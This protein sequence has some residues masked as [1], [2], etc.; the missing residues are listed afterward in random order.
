MIFA[1]MK[2]S[3]DYWDLHEELKK[4]LC[5]H[6]PCVESGLQSDSWFWIFIGNEKV[7]IDTFSSTRH[8]VKSGK[9]GPHVQQV[10]DALLLNYQVTV[11]GDPILEGHEGA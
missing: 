9:G 4:F 7:A 1:E 10:I 2:Y 6:F 5:S 8:Q 11:Y 3:D